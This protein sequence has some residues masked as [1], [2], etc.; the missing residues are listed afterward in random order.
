M[1]SP[2]FLSICVLWL[3]P[4]IEPLTDDNTLSLSEVHAAGSQ[5][6]AKNSHPDDRLVGDMQE[7][8]QGIQVLDRNCSCV[9]QHA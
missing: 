8:G 6:Q 2:S 5:G 9:P 1:A 4:G 7:R 3:L